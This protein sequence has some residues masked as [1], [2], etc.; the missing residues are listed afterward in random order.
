[1]NIC[2]CLRVHVSI[3]EHAIEEEFLCQGLK[4][5]QLTL[6]RSLY[7]ILFVLIKFTINYNVD[8]FIVIFPL[9]YKLHGNGFL[10]CLIHCCA[11][12]SQLH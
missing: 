4:E 10:S 12:N 11:P 3:S 2:V 6:Y 7:L 5:P 9:K 8:L 1:M